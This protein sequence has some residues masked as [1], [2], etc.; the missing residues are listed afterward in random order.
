[1]KDFHPYIQYSEKI[2]MN[3]FIQCCVTFFEQRYICD[4]F[5]K[6][7]GIPI[8]I[9]IIKNYFETIDK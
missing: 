5:F 6:L 7:Q 4:F 1:M 2:N 8:Y 9:F 3:S